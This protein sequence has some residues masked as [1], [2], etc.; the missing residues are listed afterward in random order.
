MHQHRSL[1][2]LNSMALLPMVKGAVTLCPNP[3]TSLPGTLRLGLRVN[4]H[5]KSDRKLG[6][7]G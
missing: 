2:V 3:L 4:S 6:C 5:S 1:S 7:D